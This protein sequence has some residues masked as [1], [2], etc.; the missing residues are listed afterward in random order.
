MSMGQGSI[1][2]TSSKQKIN[3]KS[4]TETEV[5]STD[6]VMPQMLWTKYFLDAQ[7]YTCSHQLQQDNTS[8][9]R[10]ELNG[11]ASSG[12][13]TK[14]MAVRYFF[15][16]DRVDA[17]DLTIHHCPT[18]D[19]VG[20]FFTKPLQGAAFIK[21][22]DLIMGNVAHDFTQESKQMLGPSSPRSVLGDIPRINDEE[23]PN[24][25]SGPEG[26]NKSAGP[27]G[28]NKNA[29]DERANQDWTLVKH[30]KRKVRIRTT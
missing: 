17:G 10:L 15:I 30:R 11:K 26:L 29:R 22:R 2:N 18:G 20:D 6:D 28:L 24:K 3:T 9:M 1:Y 23:K 13:R 25:G 12:K 27:E 21:F 4:S 16:K 5:V 19:M 7:G 14:H 8:A